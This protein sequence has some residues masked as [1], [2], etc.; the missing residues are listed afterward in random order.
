MCDVTKYLQMQQ[1][2]NP[3]AQEPEVVPPEEV[4]IIFC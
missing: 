3:E 2:P 1:T 4:K